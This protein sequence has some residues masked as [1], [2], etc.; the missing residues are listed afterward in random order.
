MG[1]KSLLWFEPERVSI[2]SPNYP[3]F[4]S[5]HRLL[6]SHLTDPNLVKIFGSYNF[7]DGNNVNIMASLINSRIQSMHL[8]IFRQDM[9]GPG[10]LGDW[11]LNDINQSNNMAGI[12]R[13]GMTEAG[14][15]VGLYSFWDQLRSS[16]TNL[17]IDNCAAGGRRLD[18]E[19]LSRTVPIWRS[20]RAWDPIEQQNQMLGLSLW[21][22]LQ[23]RGSD[24]AAASTGELQYKIRS[25]YGWTGVYACPWGQNFSP[26]VIRLLQNEI[27][28]LYGTASPL[29]RATPLAEILRA[30]IIQ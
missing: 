11:L 6:A 12:A 9:N 16:N 1:M 22:P 8:D 13:T 15:I 5:Q 27:N 7:S 23:G 28:R 14:Y 21:L 24:S 18:F 19:A 4:A 3:V 26:D 17:L 29:P 30:T 10:P 25:G 20:D 2:P